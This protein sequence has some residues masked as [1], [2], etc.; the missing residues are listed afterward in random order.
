LKFSKCLMRTFRRCSVSP[1]TVFFLETR[2]DI[3]FGFWGNRIS[4]SPCTNFL[5]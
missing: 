5:P 4:G 3:W 1:P 2:P